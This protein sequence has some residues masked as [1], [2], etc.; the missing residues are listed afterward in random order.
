MVKT[1]SI[2]EHKED[3]TPPIKYT[4]DRTFVAGELRSMISI[5][6]E[7]EDICSK[8]S[9][10][11]Y[12]PY[13]SSKFYHWRSKFSTNVRIHEYLKKIDEIIE[14]RLVERGLAGKAIPMTIF[15]LKNYY[16]YT[17]QYQTKVDSTISFKVN[18]GTKVIEAV[19][20]PK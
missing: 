8:A 9:L 19:V 15:L 3:Y 18:R 12:K 17:D 6:D 20:K 11:K 7:H 2:T 13:S 4:Y 5:L 16:N 10:F 14:S 1:K